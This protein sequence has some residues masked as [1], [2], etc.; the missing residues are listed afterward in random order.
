M[1]IRV[2]AEA[3]SLVAS[4]CGK[5]AFP[6][7]RWILE[8]NLY[9]KGKVGRPSK[10]QLSKKERIKAGVKAINKKDIKSLDN[11][12]EIADERPL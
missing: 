6:R 11:V 2:R 4:D 1:D 3:E 12:I 10:G 9:G 7:L 8:G 5:E